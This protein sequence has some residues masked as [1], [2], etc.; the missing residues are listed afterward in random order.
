MYNN[1]GKKKQSIWEYE[2]WLIATK[3][4]V[5]WRLD[6]VSVRHSTSIEDWYEWYKMCEKM[7]LFTS[8]E[9]N[10]RRRKKS[11]QNVKEKAIPAI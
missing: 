2:C 8:D 7:V 3:T 5:I 11:M 1:K 6:C 9:T 4:F 10:R